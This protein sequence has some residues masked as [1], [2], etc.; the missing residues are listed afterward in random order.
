MQAVW[1]TRMD[2]LATT[3]AEP[4]GVTPGAG[5]RLSGRTVAVLALLLIAAALG[6]HFFDAEEASTAA[7]KVVTATLAMA[8][9][10][11]ALVVLLWRPRA[12]LSALEVLGFGIALSFGIVQV[13]TVLAVSLHASPNLILAVLGCASILMALLAGRRPAI[14]VIVTVDELIVL[15]LLLVVAVP[16]YV[17]GSPV[18][19][20]EDQVLV[21]I[22]RRL[23]ELEAPRLDNLYVAPGVVYTYPF[24]GA[25]YFMALIA[26]L[27]DI[28]ALFLYHKLRFFW[29]PAALV[30]LY[31]A[32]RCVFGRPAVACAVTV[33]AAVLVCSGAFAMVAGFP[34]WWGQLVP[35][36]YV[37]DVAMTVLLPALLVVAFG[38]LQ[39]DAARER[40]FFLAAAA[41]LVLMLTMIHIREV[42]QFA[43][44]LGCFVV[45]TAAVRA[46]RPYLGR[47][48]ALLLLTVV[49]AVIYTR[50]QATIVPGVNDI[51]EGYRAELLSSAA[52]LPLR[53]LVLGPASN[54]LGD[55]IQDFDQVFSGLTPFFLFGGPAVVL[56]FRQRPLVW[57]ISSSTVAY[58]AVMSVPLLAIPYVYL[59]YFE[60]LHIP[61]RNVIFF[62]YL[63]AGALLYIIVVAVTLVDRTRLLPVVAGA[64]G[65][66]L[67]LLAT[68][69]LNRSHGGFFAP[70]IAA[71]G[72]TFVFAAA[73]P[74]PRRITA[75]GA[76][77]AL[78]GSVALI[79]LWPDHPPVPRTASVNVRW[80]PE[81]PDARRAA[82]ERQFGLIG[83]ERTANSSSDV[84]VWGYR[85]N[86]LSYENVKALVT[87]PD[88]VDTNDIDRATFTVP[89][90][91]PRRDHQFVGVEYAAWL[92]YPGTLL[93]VVT[94]L[95]VWVMAIVVPALLAT[96][97]DG[98][99]IS[100]IGQAMSE[101]FYKRAL[102]F[103]LFIIPFA[104]W[105]ARPT[106]SPVSLTPMPPAGRADTPHALIAQ[107]P[108][109]TTPRMPA[110]FAEE[111][112]VLPE[113]TT[114]P[115]DRAVID[116]VQ[117]H[118][119]VD[120]VFAV[121]RWTPYPPQVFM[122]QQA[123]VFPTLDAS[124]IREDALFRE[125]YRVFEER[126]R[127]YRVQPFFNVVET[128]TER[129][130]FVK[131]LG[132]THVLVSP[133]H[134]A[135][136]RPV[137]DALPGQFALRYDHAQ[138][139]IYEVV[140]SRD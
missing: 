75:R 7:L 90:Q 113:R 81:L 88:V 95:L 111:E 49:V 139:A 50:W 130:A 29:G 120:A 98:D 20:Y 34:S 84:N 127:R 126:V 51:V 25:L 9:V 41:M 116:W 133:A 74:L 99:A 77:L 72:M 16:L 134:Y 83:G 115:P 58:L 92:Q 137:L 4:V 5:F 97:G 45:V 96:V 28:D 19:A 136:L 123:V 30:M 38:Y 69:C 94:A 43:A 89:A 6:C 24:P 129:A 100:R 71:Y 18:D 79:A 42:V 103:A 135:E 73:A 40:S 22:M 70:L 61:I 138:W 108:C 102:P 85:L 91:V 33:T 131:A 93:L 1:R 27:G 39:S 110:R 119:P 132:V 62:V 121:D 23:S 76:I 86:D 55:F 53:T 46:F 82:L 10:P 125:Y 54:A 3:G 26:R 64:T 21:A 87:H 117:T 68:L 107:I 31:L 32:A 63:L 66:A 37:P 8:V 124:F 60:I 65:G 36:S 35:Y 105:S 78:T 13:L 122:S 128:P 11:G 59:T 44:Y 15:A 114:C 101:P 52:A 2:Q 67:A 56:L 118:V 104:L 57:L 112:L 47:A 109:V 12:Q 14:A 106:L 80:T 140:P 17:Q 48:V